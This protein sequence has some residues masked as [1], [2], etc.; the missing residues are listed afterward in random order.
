MQGEKSNQV[1]K[2]EGD[3][4][5]QDIVPDQTYMAIGLEPDLNGNRRKRQRTVSPYQETLCHITASSNAW[6]DQLTAA[7][8]DDDPDHTVEPK[9]LPLNPVQLEG[10][11]A[12]WKEAH[13][14][15]A[16]QE[17]NACKKF[18]GQLLANTSQNDFPITNAPKLAL[19]QKAQRTPPKKML[20]VRSDGKLISPKSKSIEV[21]PDQNHKGHSRQAKARL[22]KWVVFRFGVD[23]ESRRIIAQKVNQNPSGPVNKPCRVSGLNSAKTSSKAQALVGPPKPTHPFFLGSSAQQINSKTLTPLRDETKTAGAKRGEIAAESDTS[24]PPDAKPVTKPKLSTSAWAAFGR[25]GSKNLADADQTVA[26]IQGAQEPLWPSRGMSHVRGLVGRS[27]TQIPVSCKQLAENHKLKEVK[28]S[29]VEQDNILYPLTQTVDAYRHDTRLMYSHGREMLRRPGPKRRV[30]TGRQ[31]QWAICPSLYHPSTRQSRSPQATA[32]DED[33]LDAF[34]FRVAEL[35]PVI[36]RTY[37]KIASSLTA[38]DKGECENQEW[39][40]KHAPKCAA[41][42]LQQGREV[43][44]LRDWL[45]TLQVNSVSNCVTGNGKV[46]RSSD[47]S[48][49]LPRSLK[50]RR[51]KKAEDLDGFLITSDDE[52]DEM[53]ELS[54]ML[55]VESATDSHSQSRRSVVRTGCAMNNT[56]GGEHRKSTNAVVVSGPH[57]C[58]KTAAIYA[59]SEELGFEV[60]EIN[61]GSRRNGKDLMERVGEMSQN[62]LVHRARNNELATT[63]P[64]SEDGVAEK[65][66]V[67]SSEDFKRDLASGRQGTVKSFFQ[68]KKATK[69]DKSKAAVDAPRINTKKSRKGESTKRQSLVLLEE[70]DVLFEEDKQFWAATLDFLL[71]SKRPIVMT[72]TNESLLPLDQM[73]LHAIFRFSAAP[74]ELAIDYLLLIAAN[75]GHLLSRDAVSILYQHKKHDLRASIQELNFFCQMAVGDKKGGL[76]WMLIRSSPDECQDESGE[77]LRVVS[78]GTYQMGMGMGMLGCNRAELPSG[79]TIEQ[80]TD[81]IAAAWNDW[82]VDLDDCLNCPR[83]ARLPQDNPPS[84][85]ARIGILETFENVA[86]SLSATDTFPG[87][88]FRRDLTVSISQF[89][90]YARTNKSRLPLILPFPNQ[91]RKYEKTSTLVRH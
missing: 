79:A 27:M 24:Q 26:K 84:R 6:Q 90:F 45:Q 40:Q 54:D 47:T 49:K 11:E 15:T 59:V 69:R 46:R 2:P 73:R 34:R 51:K 57:G 5:N 64:S 38:F 63:N 9:C 66:A 48:K 25:F 18:P 17:T 91:Q 68:P 61:A 12:T 8:F 74:K 80:E 42:V 32:S 29:I 3:V 33:R 37:E 35:H 86:D 36:R 75:E 22:Q 50:R 89:M 55:N 62:H 31:L 41:D 65:E 21:I 16:L 77:Q 14:S 4:V 52:A 43:M 82:E 44:L 81:L 13:G 60:F 72:C 20:K 88:G 23:A 56:H 87:F 28:V 30:M 83:V 10:P 71:Q 7:A 1:E 19:S 70:V 53:E 67:H 76:E 58:G 85:Q 39:A 78:E